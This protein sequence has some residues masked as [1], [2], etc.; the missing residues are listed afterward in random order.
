MVSKEVRTTSF[1]LTEA[2]FGE[3]F[4]YKQ[5]PRF[6]AAWRRL[7]DLKRPV[8]QEWYRLPDASLRTALT[9]VSGDFVTLDAWRWAREDWAIV[10][11]KPISTDDM[12][13]VL[14]AWEHVVWPQGANGELANAAEEFS[15]ERVSIAD[16]LGWR[17]GHCPSPEGKWI[18]KAATWEVAHRLSTAKLRLDEG[19]AAALRLDSE[20][21]LL[22]WDNLQ[23]AGPDD[24]CA[25][26]HA[27]TPRL[28]TV[29]GLEEPVVHIQS[30]YVRLGTA[31]NRWIKHAWIEQGADLPLLYTSVHPQKDDSTGEWQS[32]WSDLT[33]DVLRRC[34]LQVPAEPSTIEL[35]DFGSLRARMQTPPQW[36]K[37]GT[38]TGQMF[39]EAVALHARGLLPDAAPVELVKARLTLSRPPDS[40]TELKMIDAAVQ[41]AGAD[42][43]QITC[44]YGDDRT[45]QR[46]SRELVKLLGL[47]NDAVRFADNG[48][49]TSI[50]RV[51]V[52]FV[53]PP[54]AANR[55]SGEADRH[56]LEAWV[57]PAIGGPDGSAGTKVIRAAIIETGDPEELRKSG[58]DPKHVIRRA[59]ADKGVVT[60][61]LSTHNVDDEQDVDHRAERAVWDLLRSAGVFPYPFPSIDGNSSNTWLVGVHVVQRQNDRKSGYKRKW[62]EGFV[63]SIVAVK[64]GERR[65][66][67]FDDVRGWRPLHEFTASFLASPHN[68]DKASAQSVVETAVNQLLTR[69]PHSKAILFLDAVGCRR[70]WNAL[71]D[72]RGEE[73]PRCARPDRVGIV[74]V[75]PDADEVPRVAGVGDW[76]P[77]GNLGPGKPSIRNALYRL[78]DED[79]PGA[80]YYVSSS[81]T[82]DRQGAHRDHTRFSCKP[83]ELRKNWHAM[84]MTEFWSPFPGPFNAESLYKLSAVLCR[85]APTWIGTLE[86]PSPMH[87]AKAIVEDH[88]DKYE[89]RDAEGQTVES[90]E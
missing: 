50:G 85:H 2:Y 31:W 63:V 5:G 32:Q 11:R 43:L 12:R 74:R 36:Y 73:L 68:R 34:N 30:S 39:H 26:M 70:F 51:S 20:A 45:R 44:L 42:C 49:A 62:N 87:L 40:S 58:Q 64:A 46:V 84:T 24:Q 17:R 72:T 52:V 57:I 15:V 56:D 59:L 8:D 35:L 16:L 55:L 69:D 9:V 47:R 83:A 7:S 67:G 80:M 66:M 37:I 14:A 77:D 18:W 4:V 29:P 48:I 76:P 60:Q 54:G 3:V 81:P 27:I 65:S 75:R 86:R 78:K 79:W 23:R 6:K 90:G 88:P 21:C 1:R 38:G 82:M 61:F 13:R 53:S 33:P 28:I 22:T 10:S 89:A 71:A 19:Y 41:A 25:A